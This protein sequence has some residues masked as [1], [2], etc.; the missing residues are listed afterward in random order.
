MNIIGHLTKKLSGRNPREKQMTNAAGAA[1]NLRSML[2][3]ATTDLCRQYMPVLLARPIDYIVPTV[4]GPTPDAPL[5]PVQEEMHKRVTPAIDRMLQMVEPHCG[6]A[7][8]TSMAQFMVRELFL[9]KMA[10]LVQLSRNRA[11]VHLME[12]IEQPDSLVNLE[13]MGSA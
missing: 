7:S 5:E 2:R 4:W 12:R 8:D 13:P 3:E 9:S 1:E 6:G 11:Y 10:F